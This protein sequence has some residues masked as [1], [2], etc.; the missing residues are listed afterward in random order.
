MS[1]KLEIPK[2]TQSKPYSILVT[3]AT[4]FIGSKL[5]SRLTDSGYTVK[6]MSRQDIS[7]TPGVKFVKADALYKDELEIVL[8][9]VEV[10]YY[11]LHSMEGHKNE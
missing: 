3:G 2:F 11:L 9:G 4:G 1:Q 7:D 8:D 6:A 5:V 10:V